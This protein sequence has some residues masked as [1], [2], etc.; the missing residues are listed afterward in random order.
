MKQSRLNHFQELT[1]LTQLL[2]AAER[3]QKGPKSQK[4]RH[5]MMTFMYRAEENCLQLGKD[6][7]SPHPKIIPIKAKH[8]YK[9]ENIIVLLDL[10]S[11]KTKK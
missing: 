11:E 4:G 6:S 8:K 9:R 2:N 3:S 5:Y 1:S 10:E 7:S